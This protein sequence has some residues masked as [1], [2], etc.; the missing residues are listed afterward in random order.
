VTPPRARERGSRARASRGVNPLTTTEPPP[1]PP[2]E[3]TEAAFGSVFTEHAPPL[4]RYLA[5]RAGAAVADDLVAEVFLVAWRRRASFDPA[6]GG[7]RPWLY[8]I[9]TN[10]LHRH[11]R[12]EQRALAATARLAGSAAPAA[13]PEDR[14]ADRVD[15]AARVRTLAAGLLKLSDGDRDVL[16]LTSWAGLSADEVG[17]ALGIPAGTV[18]S[19]LHRVRRQLR[20][21]PTTEGGSA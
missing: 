1:A 13:S 18:R 21:T 3:L 15:A 14:I 2:G 7:L 8:G 9:A 20:A 11:Q 4:H 16:L 6:R 17:A 19:R 12:D 5:R 10:L